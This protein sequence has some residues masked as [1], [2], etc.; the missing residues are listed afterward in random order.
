MDNSTTQVFPKVFGC[1]ALASSVYVYFFILVAP[2]A[3]L[4]LEAKRYVARSAVTR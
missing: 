1:L 4:S 2:Q 3:R